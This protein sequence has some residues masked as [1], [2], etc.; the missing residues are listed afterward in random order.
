MTVFETGVFS[1]AEQ[2]AGQER[3]ALALLDINLGEDSGLNL[4]APLRRANPDCRIVMLSGCTE[5]AFA[6]A[7]TKMGAA[8]YLVKP[9]EGEAILSGLLAERTNDFRMP[10]QECMPL[11]ELE[12][13]HITRVLAANKG[14][15]SR[16]AQVL[17]M[18]R[19][20][21]QRKLSRFLPSSRGAAARSSAFGK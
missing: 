1:E 5:I 4:I 7:A 9:V 8:D 15:I 10:Q 16:T 3:P 14:N 18:H 21:L 13:S 12:K 11:E 19:R 17:D 6:V 2:I 20:T